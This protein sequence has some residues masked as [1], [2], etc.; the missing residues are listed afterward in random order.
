M[1]STSV[2][3]A[4]STRSNCACKMSSMVASTMYSAKKLDKL[5]KGL[6]LRIRRQTSPGLPA[7]QTASLYGHVMP[8]LCTNG[9]TDAARPVTR[10]YGNLPQVA[11]A[12]G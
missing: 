7:M 6:G 10:S 12:Q 4:C 5:D 11:W 3:R 1:E 8:C 2:P 9:C